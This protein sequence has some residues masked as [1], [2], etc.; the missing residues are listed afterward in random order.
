MI[1]N[2]IKLAITAIGRNLLRSTLTILGIVIGVTAV[3]SMVTLG[4]GATSQ[5]TR[6]ITSLGSDLLILRPGIRG[7][8]GGIPRD[9]E[10]FK[11]ADAKA[12]NEEVG[13]IAGAT[14][15]SSSATTAVY[16]NENWSTSIMGSDNSYLSARSWELE[17][18][19][20]FTEAE[21]VGGRLS[22]ILGA[23]V[24]EKLFGYQDPLDAR[25]RVGTASCT[26]IGVLKSKGGQHSEW[27]RMILS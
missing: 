2:T 14:P 26:V 25:I 6:E 1:W 13:G 7:R 21:L 8:H 27:T 17:S 16:G 5:I 15:V 10:P 24:K 9:A 11:R 22:C 19:R 20:E 12:I 23:T 3:I 18:G 4:G